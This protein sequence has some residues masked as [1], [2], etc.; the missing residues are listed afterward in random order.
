MTTIAC[1]SEAMAGDGRVSSNGPDRLIHFDD[2]VKVQRVGD[3]IVGTCGSRYDFEKFCNWIATK[4]S[5]RPELSPQFEALVLHK[6]GKILCYNRLCDAL[7]HTAPAAIGSGAAIAYGAMFMGANA[8]DA[9][10][11]ASRYD[12]GTG[13]LITSI[14]IDDE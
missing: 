8:R 1:T 14:A 6:A 7:S 9:V 2:A 5:D 10:R 12:L 4:T 3:L 11:A 13:G